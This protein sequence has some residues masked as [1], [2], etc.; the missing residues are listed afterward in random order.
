MVVSF[1]G[2][3]NSQLVNTPHKSLYTYASVLSHVLHQSF[4]NGFQRRN[5]PSFGFRNY[6]HASAAATLYLLT[7]QLSTTITTTLLTLCT[8]TRPA[9]N[10]SARAA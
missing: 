6:P 9:H 1:I 8:L 4:G 10:I 5:L 7:N 3:F 2:R